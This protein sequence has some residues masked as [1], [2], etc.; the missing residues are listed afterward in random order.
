MSADHTGGDTGVTNTA[1]LARE[2]GEA[3]GDAE[4]QTGAVCL[5]AD[6]IFEL[7]YHRGWRELNSQARTNLRNAAAGHATGQGHRVATLGLSL[8]DPETA[9]LFMRDGEPRLLHL[10]RDDPDVLTDGGV[11]ERSLRQSIEDRELNRRFDD[12]AWSKLNTLV[13]EELYSF[14]VAGGALDDVVLEHIQNA[15]DELERAREIRAVDL[16]AEL[17]ADIIGGDADE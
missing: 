5:E 2:V 4:I 7:N 1:S 13:D 3:L 8:M 15:R 14:G 6:C 10:A 11:D 9:V 12:P 17:V 16:R